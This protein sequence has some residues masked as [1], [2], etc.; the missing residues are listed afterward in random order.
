MKRFISLIVCIGLPFTSLIFNSPVYGYYTNMPASVV[1]GQTNFT[2]NTGSESTGVT[3]STLSSLNVVA[4]KLFVDPNGKLIVADEQNM[5]VLIWNSVPTVNGKSADLVLGQTNFTNNLA[6]QGGTLNA[7]TLN[8]PS[9]VWS[10]GNK[11]IVGDRLNERVLIWNTFPTQ[12]DQPADVVVGQP[13]MTTAA[14]N[15]NST[16]VRRPASV[17]VY[18]GKLIIGSAFNSQRVLIYNSIPTSNGAAA[19]LVL[20]QTTMNTCGSVAT[21]ASR[22]L[23]RAVARVDDRGRL[24][25]FD[26]GLN[27]ILIWNTFPTINNQPAD[28]VVGQPDFT[29][30]SAGTSASK[31]N[32]VPLTMG[33]IS[34]FGNRLFVADLGNNRILIFN[35]PPTANGASADLVLGQSDFT[36]SST[37]AGGSTSSRAFNEPGDVITYNDKVLVYDLTN[38]RI[39]VFNNVISTPSTSLNSPTN[40]NTGK[41]RIN[42]NVQLGERPNYALQHV[43]VNING[44]GEG[45]VTYKDNGRDNGPGSTLYEFYHDVEGWVGS[46]GNQSDWVTNPGGMFTN[47]G[48]TASFRVSS[49]NT[50]EDKVFYFT[51]FSLDSL[52]QVSTTD[53]SPS[54]SFTVNK[55][56]RNEMKNNLKYYQVWVKKD[57]DKDFTKYIDNIPVDFD[58]VKSTTDN[59]LN[60]KY[61]SSL[62]NTDGTYETKDL[63]INYSSTSSKITVKSK[64]PP[65]G[66]LTP[67]TYLVQIKAINIMNREQQ[68][69][70]L[71]LTI[72]KRT[73]PVTNPVV[74]TPTPT[75]TPRSL[76]EVGPTPIPG[77]TSSP[78]PLPAQAGKTCFLFWCW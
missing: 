19:D 22:I 43:F 61:F 4:A 58:T 56:Q 24:Y 28:L 27:R 23:D 78:R 40:L 53:T 16:S 69:N 42:G 9:G 65:A 21:S 72:S 73:I 8:K 51:P 64:T 55:S 12:N 18:N 5:R 57:S 54:F 68:S 66:G 44:Q 48:F 20:G 33:G 67:G 46:N 29:T 26:P 39:L 77:P 25:I 14:V 30:V 34:I 50:D 41:Y 70:N 62:P 74:S 59:L 7:A 52:K 17:T 6:N 75:F 3:S 47:P 76:D 38:A 1:V 10:D 2:N 60:Y 63:T 37:D 32:S 35:S 49:Y 71:N 11:L 13:D 15:C 36:S 31:F 45:D